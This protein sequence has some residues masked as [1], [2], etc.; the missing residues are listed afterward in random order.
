LETYDK[1][2]IGQ[3]SRAKIVYILSI[4]IHLKYKLKNLPFVA[5][6]EVIKIS[7]NLEG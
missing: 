5:K 7:L 1:C 4:S 3:V 6:G 2:D